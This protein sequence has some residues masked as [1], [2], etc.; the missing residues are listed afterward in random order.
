MAVQE[1]NLGSEQTLEKILEPTPYGRMARHQGQNHITW[2]LYTSEDANKH[3]PFSK[4]GS[5]MCNVILDEV[6]SH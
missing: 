3:N 4:H 5:Q 2:Q 1:D 6:M